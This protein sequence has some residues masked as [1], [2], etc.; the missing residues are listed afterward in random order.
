MA[1]I[2]QTTR[3]SKEK[4]LTT[5]SPTKAIGKMDLKLVMAGTQI[6]KETFKK[7]S[8]ITAVL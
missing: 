3:T 7:E 8:G 1:L 5:E 6:S 2:S 4:L